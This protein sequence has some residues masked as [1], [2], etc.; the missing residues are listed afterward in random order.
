M[1]Y[2]AITGQLVVETHAKYCLAL[3][4][5]L[6]KDCRKGLDS[7]KYEILVSLVQWR[8]AGS[9]SRVEN[10]DVG[11]CI[12]GIEEYDDG[13]E[14]GSGQLSEC[15]RWILNIEYSN[16][17]PLSRS[18]C[19]DGAEI[20]EHTPRYRVCARITTMFPRP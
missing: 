20:L 14:C 7:M 15:D 2:L 12:I 4:L 17:R 9:E 8:I 11:G 3:R 1:T 18:S 19:V 13:V 10:N 6:Q 5:R 16:R